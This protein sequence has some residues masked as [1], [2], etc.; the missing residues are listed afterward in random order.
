VARAFKV[1]VAFGTETDTAVVSSIARDLRSGERLMVDANQGWDL[2]EARR[3]GSSAGSH[4]G[5]KT[6]PAAP[7]AYGFS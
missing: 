4:C 3:A 2:A 7:G 6:R 5:E 1:K